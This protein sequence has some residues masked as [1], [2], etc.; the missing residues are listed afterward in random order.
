MAAN[1]WCPSGRLFEAAA[2]G[3]AILSDWWDGLDEFFVPGEEIA[4]VRSTADVLTTL[5]RGDRELRELGEAGRQRALADH[6]AARRA[7][8]LVELLSQAR[9]ASGGCRVAA[10]VE[11]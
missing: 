10:Q 11:S 9:A 3:T 8:E 4:I 7:A 2:C 1:G 5:E 6:T